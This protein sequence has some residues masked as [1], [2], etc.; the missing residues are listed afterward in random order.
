MQRNCRR[1]EPRSH[2]TSLRFECDHDDA[3]DKAFV[4]FLDEAGPR[5]HYMRDVSGE[6]VLQPDEIADAG[7]FAPDDLPMMP[8][9]MSIA[10]R[11]IEDWRT[12]AR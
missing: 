12:G 9:T 3:F 11:I 6:L 5:T 8:P 4:A 2:C 7:W 1:T 10:G